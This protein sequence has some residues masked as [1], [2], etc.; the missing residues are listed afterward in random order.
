MSSESKASAM[1]VGALPFIV[2]IMVWVINPDYMS[3]FFKEDR[4]IV[5]GLG[6]MVWM[7]IGVAVMAKM[8]NFEI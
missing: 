7:S 6:A 2:F 1:I 4:L 8:V 5:A 3:G